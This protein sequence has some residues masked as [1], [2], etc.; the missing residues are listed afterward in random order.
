METKWGFNV[1]W[2]EFLM[3][4]VNLNWNRWASLG[5]DEKSSDFSDCIITDR[6]DLTFWI[7][8][9]RV[10]ILF[11]T[12]WFSLKV[13]VIIISGFITFII[14]RLSVIIPNASSS[15]HVV[16]SR[17]LG[18][19]PRFVSHSKH[20]SN[21]ISSDDFSSFWNSWVSSIWKNKTVI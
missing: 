12:W 3:I 20:I 2:D 18:S 10:T 1:S 21:E 17:F 13:E 4:E 14:Y 8:F 16:N 15:L 5:N 7:W 9:S 19:L 11:E 6:L